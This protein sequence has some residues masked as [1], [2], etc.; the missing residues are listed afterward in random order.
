MSLRSALC[1]IVCGMSVLGT[2]NCGEGKYAEA[3]RVTGKYLDAMEMF[4]LSVE[5]AS[6][7]E[8]LVQAV[9]ELA[10][11][12]DELRPEMEA[13]EN[14]YPELTDTETPPPR[15][16]GPRAS[17]EYLEPETDCGSNQNHAIC[18]GSGSPEGSSKAPK[19]QI[20]LLLLQPRNSTC[21]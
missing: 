5:E 1:L 4:A 19:H 17:D 14:K 3:K 2:M 11:E 8:A 16:G 7:P 10:A 6:D 9:D 15:D 20:N 13:V 12:M 18:L 21:V